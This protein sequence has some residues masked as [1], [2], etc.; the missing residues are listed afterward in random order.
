M[1]DKYFMKMALD[2]AK[3][4]LGFTSPNPMVGAV[5]VKDGRVVGK[6]FHEAVGGAHAEVNAIDDAKTLTEGG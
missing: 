2:L 1:D 5:V 3:K 6:G 4:G